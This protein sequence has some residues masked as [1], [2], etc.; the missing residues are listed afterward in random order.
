MNSLRNLFSLLAYG[1]RLGAIN[2]PFLII[3]TGLLIYSI[4]DIRTLLNKDLLI[5]IVLVFANIIWQ[6]VSLLFDIIKLLHH[7]GHY[8]DKNNFEYNLSPAVQNSYKIFE[9]LKFNIRVIYSTHANQIL[10][11]DKKISIISSNRHKKSVENYINQNQGVLL[12]FL[13]AKWH[14]LKDGAFFNESKLC[15]ASEFE[16]YNNETSIRVNKGCYY[17]SFVT[18]DI[19]QQKLRHQDGISLYP[20]LNAKT[21]PI[22]EFDNSVFSN[23]IGVS[24]MAITLDGYIIVL[25]HNNKSAISSNMYAPSASG[26]VDYGDWKHSEDRD[27]R[28]ILIRAAHREL[29]EETGLK[30]ELI[31]KTE[32]I[33]V[34]RDL[35][36]GGKPEYCSVAYLNIR[37]NDAKEA[38]KAEKK[39]VQ[40]KIE[41]I[42]IFDS[43]GLFNS[44]DFD[45]FADTHQNLISIPLYMNMFF[46]R[47]YMAQNPIQG[48]VKQ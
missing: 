33:G 42:R 35:S 12:L 6:V 20:P 27:F 9:D 15:Q 21:T 36:R 8:L 32:I 2:L 4:V 23:H 25:Q 34:Y 43:S 45:N 29:S 30:K 11:S 26:S 7:T 44:V 22:E 47:S 28:Q 48:D 13:K 31:I 18:N 41:S 16:E 37:K 1:V 40:N 19:Y 24:L 14:S 39:E 38:F 10:N 17:N 46:L 5:F 3:N